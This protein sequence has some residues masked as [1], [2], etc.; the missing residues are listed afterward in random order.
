MHALNSGGAAS[1]GEGPDGGP[2]ALDLAFADVATFACDAPLPPLLSNLT[3]AE[4][5]DYVELRI[6]KFLLDDGGL[7]EMMAAERFG[8]ACATATDVDACTAKVAAAAPADRQ[9]GWR[10][11]GDHQGPGLGVDRQVIV[12]TRGDD[13]TVLSRTDEVRSFLG[14]IDSFEEARLLLLTGNNPLECTTDPRSGWRKN[15]DGSFELLIAGREC[16]TMYGYRRRFRVS[17]DGVITLVSGTSSAARLEQVCGRRPDGLASAS[18]G[19]EGVGTFFAHAS[20]QS[21]RHLSEL[22]WSALDE[23]L[24]RSSAKPLSRSRAKTSSGSRAFLDI[25]RRASC[26]TGSKACCP[27]QR[28][29]RHEAATSPRLRA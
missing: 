11:D 29:A 13:V 9:D 15:D 1:G 21:S 22:R 26:S 19:S 14:S 6:Q 7:G 8:A 3:P 2:D 10:F 18:P 17:A 27:R 20:S 25:M 4:P 12:L 28:E 5:V 16:G 23:T 24:S